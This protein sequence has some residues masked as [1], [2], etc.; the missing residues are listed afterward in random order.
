[1]LPVCKMRNPFEPVP[2]ITSHQSRY[3]LSSPK[4]IG[5]ICVDG[6]SGALIRFDDTTE[7]V[8]VGDMCKGHLIVSIKE[9]KVIVRDR[10]QREKQWIMK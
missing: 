10:S 3:N 5:I 6:V 8:Y 2:V 1:M 4:V 7:V 9:N